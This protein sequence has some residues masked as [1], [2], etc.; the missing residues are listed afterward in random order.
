[1]LS[2]ESTSERSRDRILS[3]ESR[4]I[5]NKSEDDDAE[6]ISSSNDW[7]SQSWENVSEYT[8]NS[9]FSVDSLLVEWKQRGLDR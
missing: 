1:M 4:N 8:S 5:I 3:G 9:D 6:S 2:G 7:Q